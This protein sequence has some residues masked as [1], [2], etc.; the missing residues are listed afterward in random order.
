MS[1][2]ELQLW[3]ARFL[4]GNSGFWHNVHATFGSVGILYKNLRVSDSIPVESSRL[5]FLF[6]FQERKPVYILL[7]KFLIL[8]PFPTVKWHFSVFGL[9]VGLGKRD[10]EV[11]WNKT[12]ESICQRSFWYRK[13]QETENFVTLSFIYFFNEIF[14]SGF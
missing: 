11:I 4:C 2:M 3:Q 9:R 12:E 13:K 7:R 1:Q 10:S 14:P 5:Y 6:H 8:Y